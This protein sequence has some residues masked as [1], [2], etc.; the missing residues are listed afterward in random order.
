[1]GGMEVVVAKKMVTAVT[2]QDSEI[3]RLVVREQRRM[4]DAYPAKTARRL[5]AERLYQ[6]KPNARRWRNKK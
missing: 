3:I 6:L 5:L 2:I 4:K 1:M